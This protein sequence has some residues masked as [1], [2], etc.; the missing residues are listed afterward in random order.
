MR[1]RADA[2]NRDRLGREA[3]SDYGQRQRPPATADTGQRQHL[4]EPRGLPGGGVDADREWARNRIAGVFR[5]QRFGTQ[6][7]R[8]PHE[9]GRRA[10]RRQMG[11]RAPVRGASRRA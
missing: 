5:G 3:V 4:D 7:Q 10:R 8:K 6:I 2:A 1:S 9:G 11:F